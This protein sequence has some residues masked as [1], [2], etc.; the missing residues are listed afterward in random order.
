[1]S[2]WVDTV[3]HELAVDTRKLIAYRQTLDT[4]NLHQAEESDMVGEMISDMHFALEWIRRG[5]SPWSRRGVDQRGVYQRTELASMFPSIVPNVAELT[6]E[7]RHKIID[8]LVS[9]SN[10]ERACFLL[11]VTKGLTYADIAFKL[12]VS[13]TSVQKFVERA[14][15]KVQQRI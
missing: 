11:H 13:R 12:D 15:I 5:R 1:M 7:D 3:K 6:N 8:I 10:R 9:L 4:T 2:T 14:R